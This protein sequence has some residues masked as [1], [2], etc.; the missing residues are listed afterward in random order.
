MSDA[1]RPF[2][3]EADY[4][5]AGD[6]PEAI[7]RLVDGLQDGLAHQTLLGVTGS[8]KSIGYDDEIYIVEHVAGRSIASIRKAG[9]FIDGLMAE[10]GVA[11]EGERETVRYSCVNRSFST[12]AY[13]V[14]RGTS[15]LHRI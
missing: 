7:A 14:R 2:Q 9:P 8:G 15:G 5:P 3:L 12:H 6:Q 1:P 13:D 11:I 10:Q 4:R